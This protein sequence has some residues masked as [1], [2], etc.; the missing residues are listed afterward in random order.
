MNGARGGVQAVVDHIASGKAAGRRLIEL[1][2]FAIYQLP[3]VLRAAPAA[4]DW[5]KFRVRAGKYLGVDVSGTDGANDDPDSESLF[6]ADTLDISVPSG[7]PS[8][9]FW[10]DA[11]NPAAPAL[12]SGVTPPT[13]DSSHVAI[14]MVDTSTNAAT[15]QAV[16]RQIVRTDI[17]STGAG[18]GLGLQA[19]RLKYVGIDVLVCKAWDGANEG[20][21]VTYVARN[22]KLRCSIASEILDGGE[23]DY[24]YDIS[25]ESRLANNHASQ[26]N[27]ALWVSETQT[28][29]PRYIADQDA[30]KGDIIWAVPMPA[31]TLQLALA[32][33]PVTVTYLDLNVDARSWAADVLN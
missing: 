6:E 10:L 25:W 2:P 22:P 32:N 33:D 26:I 27:P 15:R 30:G 16:V 1:F 21:T 17:I 23:W 18:S 4:N 20:P 7:T 13:F 12:K 5:L 8:F 28:I 3:S 9:W 31:A 24:T 19:F 29:V 14:G 11:S